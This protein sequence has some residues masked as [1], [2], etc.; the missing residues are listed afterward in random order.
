MIKRKP[1]T[2]TP[3]PLYCLYF[4]SV[5]SNVSNG[6][7]KESKV[8]AVNFNYFTPFAEFPS[9][10]NSGRFWFLFIKIESSFFLSKMNLTVNPG[11]SDSKSV[12]L[13]ATSHCLWNAIN[14]K[15]IS[16][17]MGDNYLR[18]GGGGNGKRGRKREE[19]GKERISPKHKNSLWIECQR[20]K[21]FNLIYALSICGE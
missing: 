10:A 16:K 14:R 12:F 5:N 13:A 15:L 18:E 8:L 3:K 11:L 4:S 9:K 6:F 1:H 19:R 20:W 7:L 21:Y 2:S 17:S